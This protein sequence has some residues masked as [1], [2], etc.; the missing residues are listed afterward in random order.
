MLRNRGASDF[1]KVEFANAKQ[2]KDAISICTMDIDFV[3]ITGLGSKLLDYNRTCELLSGGQARV[4]PKC[5][6]EICRRHDGGLVLT[7]GVIHL[8]ALGKPL[9]RGS[10][11]HSVDE[12]DETGIKTQVHMRNHIDTQLKEFHEFFSNQPFRPSLLEALVGKFGSLELTLYRIGAKHDV[13]SMVE[14][15]RGLVRTLEELSN[16]FKV[17]IALAMTL[18]I[19]SYY[20]GVDKLGHHKKHLYAF[21]NQDQVNNL[22]MPDG[23]MKIEE[24]YRL[25]AYNDMIHHGH[26]KEPGSHDIDVKMSHEPKTKPTLWSLAKPTIIKKLQSLEKGLFEKRSLDNQSWLEK[27]GLRIEMYKQLVPG[28]A[29][30]VL[31][32]KMETFIKEQMIITM[33]QLDKIGRSIYIPLK[34]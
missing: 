9:V 16:D 13:S 33:K 6:R 14:P 10:Q 23:H 28:S 17:N 3:A 8:W 29:V 12:E 20:M 2:V 31:K 7:F 26:L 5:Q 32:G 25:C 24:M 27:N 34:I 18:R 22:L 21:S 15:S 19:E 4:Y 1:V 30:S 11:L